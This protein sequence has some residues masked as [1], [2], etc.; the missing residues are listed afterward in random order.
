MIELTDVVVPDVPDLPVEPVVPQDTQIIIVAPDGTMTIYNSS[1][2][3]DVE[4]AD[5]AYSL[6]VSQYG[7]LDKP[8]NMYS[9]SEGLLLV[10]AAA[11]VAFLFGKLFKRRKF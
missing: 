2:E 5:T 11:A 6:W 7:V 4:A 3:L 8:F 10:I 9:V 1:G